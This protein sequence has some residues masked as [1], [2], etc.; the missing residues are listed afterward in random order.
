VRYVCICSIIVSIIVIHDLKRELSSVSAEQVGVICHCH[1]PYVL[2]CSD[3]R[4]VVCNRFHNNRHN[5]S[6][7]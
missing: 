3:S 4:A 7:N 2:S 1:M 6:E 5:Y